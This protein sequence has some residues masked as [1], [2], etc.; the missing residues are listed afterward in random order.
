MTSPFLR[1]WLL[2]QILSLPSAV[3]RFF[4]GGGVVYVGGRTLDA[5]I[6]F[7][8]RTWFTSAKQNVTFS[9]AGKSLET[10][11]EEW[12]Q[13]AN[14]LGLP[15][16]IKVK[17]E[18]ASGDAPG[19]IGGIV[20]KPAV[21][22]PDAPLLV[23]FH[24]GGGVIGG[25]DLSKAFCALFSHE[26]RCPVFLPDYRLAPSHRFPAA[27]DDARLAWDWAQVNAVRLGSRSGEV[28]IGGVTLG[29]N[30]AARL[31]LDLKRDF[32]PLPVAQ[33]LVTPLLD[34]ADGP[35][36]TSTDGLWPI[37]AEDIDQMVSH[38]AGAGAGADL[39]DPRVSPA[40]EK[41]IIG[42]P[43]TLIA[44]AGLDPLA[45]Q[46]EAYAKR[47]I[48][49]RTRVVYRRYDALP[50]GFDLLASVVV[51]VRS[52]TRDMAQNW[53]ELLRLSRADDS[54]PEPARNLDVA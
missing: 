40:H 4:S 13:A 51:E 14:L 43:R 18:P 31:C 19:G 24:Q 8:W 37:A 53:L 20:I 52:A 7:L 35:M 38:Y 48:A 2:R 46:A 44:A 15:R 3:L 5:Q 30:L 33:L 21:I 36:K 54:Q 23:F 9:L 41:L 50:L 39:A 42:Q 22:A 16:G 49:A 11:R 25:P 10:A 26:A 34:L 17:I 29:A 1:L 45:P 32:K 28:A 6:Q 27:C 12:Q 47:L